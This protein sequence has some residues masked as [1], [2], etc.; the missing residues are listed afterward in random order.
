MDGRF[1]YTKFPIVRKK[2]KIPLMS[3]VMGVLV[4]PS[5]FKLIPLQS[6]NSI[7]MEF[8]LDPYAMFTSGYSDYC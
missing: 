1:S 5:Q 7:L 6:I 2:F 3:A 8:T 4:D